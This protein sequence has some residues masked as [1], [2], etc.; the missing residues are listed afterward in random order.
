M[1]KVAIISSDTREA[2]AARAELEG[3]YET[4]PEPQADIIV[5]LGGDGFML[6]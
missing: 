1:K 6:V 2:K 4:V 3:L 5:A